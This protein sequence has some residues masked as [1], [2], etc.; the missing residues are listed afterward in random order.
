L[1]VIVNQLKRFIE[2]L[3]DYLK[4]SIIDLYSTT[5]ACTTHACTMC[6]RGVVGYVYTAHTKLESLD[7]N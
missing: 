3:K 7:V 5:Y 1:V 4:V 2:I 6:H